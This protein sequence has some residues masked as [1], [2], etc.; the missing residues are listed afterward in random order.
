MF[1]IGFI[2]LLVIFVLLLLVVGPEK[3]PELAKTIGKAMGELKKSTDELKNTIHDE[4][5]EDPLWKHDTDDA[6]LKG[7][8]SED[9]DSPSKKEQSS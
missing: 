2:E 9:E 6:D 5:K 7:E 4:S 1:G 3:L 8:V